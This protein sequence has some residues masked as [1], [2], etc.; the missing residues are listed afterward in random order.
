MQRV[1]AMVLA[2]GAGERLSILSAERAKPAVPFAGR[3]RIIDFVLSNCVNSGIFKVAILTQYNPRSL[4][5]HIGIGKPWDLDR[6]N[7]GVTILQPYLGLGKGE[8]NRGTADAIHQNLYFVQDHKVED[9]LVL[10]GDHIYTMRYD[11]MISSHRQRRADVTVGVVEVP[12][13]EA[14][15]FGLVTLSPQDRI[16][17][18]QE[19]PA[20]P[21]SNL[22][23]MGIYVFNREALFKILEQAIAGGRYDFGRDVL[24]AILD[25]YR[26]FAYRFRGYWRD[27]GT[28]EAYWQA[29]MDL[30]QD[31]PPF[32]LY[33]EEMSIHSKVRDLPP[34]KT[35]PNA[36]IS[37]S[38]V[39]HG[40]II[41]GTVLNSILSPGV[42]VEEGATVV[43]SVLFDDV[44][45]ERGVVVH[46]C[47]VDKEVKIG[48]GSTLGFGEDNTPNRDKPEHLNTGITIVGKGAH[49][50]PGIKVG[51]NVKI[52]CWAEQE[53]FPSDF[54]PSGESV[55]K[56]S[57][58][59]HR[60]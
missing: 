41:N 59:R 36:R 1:L 13:E 6:S 45:V 57:P 32:N 37:R 44:E 25:K 55:E 5:A 38:L 10:A 21:A 14:H 52:I 47:I 27:V 22:A 49:I 56:K 46:R 3:Y 58:G 26:V 28:V 30:I 8:W 53:D 48:A 23:S 42:Y 40:C 43:D 34:S 51:R 35:G 60:V 15:R 39:S 29:S 33:D 19:K 7:G 24:P 31:L 54:I 17:E 9:V 4:S 2:G 12:L 16:I 11:H 20:H 18:W 50:P